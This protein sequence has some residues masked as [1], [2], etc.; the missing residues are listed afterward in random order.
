MLLIFSC[1]VHSFLSVLNSCRGWEDKALQECNLS[2]QT[3]RVLQM[4]S[5]QQRY[6]LLPVSFC[7]APA[8]TVQ[9]VKLIVPHFW[10]STRSKLRVRSSSWPKSKRPNQTLCLPSLP[11]SSPTDQPANAL[12]INT[13]RLLQLMLPHLATFR[14]SIR[15]YSKSAGVPSYSRSDRWYSCAGH[16]MASASCGRS[17][18]KIRRHS[19]KP[20][21]CSTLAP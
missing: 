7:I 19:S 9:S 20:A 18:L 1:S 5:W 2:A 3:A 21:C 6:S 15:A 12:E 10:R 13:S 11:G 14:D 17:S 4:Q 16:F 8:I